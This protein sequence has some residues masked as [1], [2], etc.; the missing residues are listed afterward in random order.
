MTKAHC[1]FG[2]IFNFYF[3]VEFQNCGNYFNHGLLWI[4][5]AS[6]YGMHTNEKNEQFINI[7]ISMMY[8]V[9]KS[10]AKCTT[11]T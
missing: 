7:Y 8:H 11:T 6:M 9:T 2:H 5:D 10:S 1:L 3:I 4:K